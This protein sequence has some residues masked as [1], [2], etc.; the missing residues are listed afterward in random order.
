MKKN[1]SLSHPDGL[2]EIT[3]AEVVRQV[4][5]LIGVLPPQMQRVVKL[6][7]LEGKNY[8]EIAGH[9]NSSPETVRKQRTNALHILRQKLL[10]F[11][12]VFSFFYK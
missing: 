4:Y 10:L 8:K 11:L 7:Y 3:H 12:I 6:Y 1:L 9:L 5:G 2:D